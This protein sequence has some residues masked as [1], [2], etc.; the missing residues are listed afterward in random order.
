[1]EN[2]QPLDIR[3]LKQKHSKILNRS[4]C[5]PSMTQAYSL[6]IQYMKQW[7]LSKF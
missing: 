2:L 3:K 6:C 7:F 4:I 1:M 5:M